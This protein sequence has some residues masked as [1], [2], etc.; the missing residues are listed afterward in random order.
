MS[1]PFTQTA[2]AP[3]Y[4]TGRERDTVLA[5]LRLW[6]RVEREL[7]PEYDIACDGGTVRPCTPDE[8][9]ELCERLN[10]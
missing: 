4:L 5:A 7:M 3:H 10:A 2:A 8:V 6:Q 9:D 1:E